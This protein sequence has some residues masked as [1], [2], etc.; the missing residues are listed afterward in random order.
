M[1]L[2]QLIYLSQE[3]APLTSRELTELVAHSSRANEPRRI[4]GALYYGGGL[5]IQAI[6]GY[7]SDVLRLYTKIPDDPRAVAAYER[8][9]KHFYQKRGQLNMA[10]ADCHKFYSGN[11]V[12]ADL[13]SPALGHLTHFPVYR[14]KWGGIGT[15]HRRYGGCN[16][17]VRAKPYKAQSAEYR[18]LE[19]FHTYM[20]NGLVVNGPGARK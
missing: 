9:K 1:S 5:F 8:G 3:T 16:K 6:E 2:L 12:R 11:M 4:T 10:C 19:Y 7:Q 14:S 15:T 13:L 20:S 17:Q 18:A